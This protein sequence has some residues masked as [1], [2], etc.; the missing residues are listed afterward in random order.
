MNLEN[1]MDWKNLKNSHTHTTHKIKRPEMTT[2]GKN[3]HKWE[4]TDRMV[5][6]DH[7]H[8]WK[9]TPIAQEKIHHVP[10]NSLELVYKPYLIF[11]KKYFL[12]RTN[13]IKTQ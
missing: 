5:N 2:D 1:A 4:K 8:W 13:Y 3:F 11:E 10:P 7:Y 12:M 6:E 9:N